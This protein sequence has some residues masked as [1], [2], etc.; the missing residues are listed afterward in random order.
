MST[1]ERR[2]NVNNFDITNYKTIK[3]SDR[4]IIYRFTMERVKDTT[5]CV[6]LD[7]YHLKGK[8][9]IAA[10]RPVKIE[11]REG[12]TMEGYTLFTSAT[13]DSEAAPRFSAKALEDFAKRMLDRFTVE[14][15]AYDDIISKR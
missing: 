11:H 2:T 12:Y 6:D 1:N 5:Y 8:G 7:C 14:Y 9:Y 13:L 10:V 15:E 4:G 3:R